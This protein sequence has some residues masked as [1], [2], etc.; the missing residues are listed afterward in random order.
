[1]RALGLAMRD[2]T[3]T[4][5]LEEGLHI[6]WEFIDS[7]MFEKT[8]P[9]MSDASKQLEQDLKMSGVQSGDSLYLPDVYPFLARWAAR[10]GIRILFSTTVST[11]A[12][13]EKGNVE[14]LAHYGVDTLRIRC[15]HYIDTMVSATD[16][17]HVRRVWIGGLA[18]GNDIPD[19]MPSVEIKPTNHD[20]IYAITLD[21]PPTTPYLTAVRKLTEH[22]TLSAGKKPTFQL[23]TVTPIL[24]V[25]GDW[26]DRTVGNVSWYPYTRTTDF[27]SAIE[28][29]GEC[30]EI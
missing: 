10:L 12:S 20:Q 4:L 6:G 22:F 14:I 21:V 18:I 7:L 25:A 16:L 5:I 1:M 23:L 2:P 26:V 15:A 9:A 28:Q 24:G 11:V 29:V 13:C 3:H 27:Y 17:G 19:T 30:Y 8:R